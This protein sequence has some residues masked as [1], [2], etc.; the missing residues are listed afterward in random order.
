MQYELSGFNYNNIQE[1]SKVLSSNK[2]QDIS[3]VDKPGELGNIEFANYL[4]SKNDVKITLHYSIQ[5]HYN[6]SVESIIKNFD[7]FVNRSYKSGI[8]DFLIV[9]GSQK[10]KYT[11]FDVIR[12]Y[13]NKYEVNLYCAF[14]PYLDDIDS[15]IERLVAKSEYVHGVYLQIGDNLNRLDEVLK[16][17]TVSQALGGKVLY[18]CLLFPTK[19]FVAKFKF[20]PWKGVNLSAKYLNNMD[21]AMDIFHSYFDYY[22]AHQ[23]SPLIEIIPFDAGKVSSFQEVI[24]F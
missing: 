20:R 19:S 14:N 8:Q 7:T 6:R 17:P 3:I 2:I 11:S 24:D 12:L 21:V 1:F 18:G 16:M 23:I 13:E 4:L 10:K 22:T 5:Y 9:S 15:E